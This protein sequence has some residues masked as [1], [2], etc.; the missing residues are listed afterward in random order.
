MCIHTNRSAP[1]A[2]PN[3]TRQSLIDRLPQLEFIPHSA[4]RIS[5]RAGSGFRG[6]L[7]KCFGHAQNRQRRDGNQRKGSRTTLSAP[8]LAPRMHSVPLSRLW[9]CW[10]QFTQPTWTKAVQGPVA[11]VLKTSHFSACN[12]RTGKRRLMGGGVGHEQLTNKGT[13]EFPAFNKRTPVA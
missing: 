2:S 4:L 12:K 13:T 7:C 8:P 9:S 10:E 5:V 1:G 6:V 11:T 3:R